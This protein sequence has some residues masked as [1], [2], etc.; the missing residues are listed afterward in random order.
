MTRPPRTLGLQSI[1]R[2]VALTYYCWAMREMNPRHPDVPH[3]VVRIRE[4][5]DAAL[6]P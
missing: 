3:V 5:Q 4:L 6:S 2:L 1:F